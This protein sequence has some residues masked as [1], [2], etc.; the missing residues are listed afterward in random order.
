MNWKTFDYSKTRVRGVAKQLV[1]ND[2]S[3]KE[4]IEAINIVASFRSAHSYPMQSMLAHIRNKAYDVDMYAIVVRRLKRIPSI[5]AK[6]KRLPSMQITTMGD[7]GGIRVILRDIKAVQELSDSLKKSKTRNRLLKTDDYLAEP[8]H[9]GYRSI[10]LTY[11]YQGSKQDYKDFRVEVQIRSKVQHSWAT[12]VEVA[13]TFLRQ[14]MKAGQGDKQW[15]AFFQLI[16]PAFVCLETG[17]AIQASLQKRIDEEV[18]SLKVFDLL[19]SFT[20]A[21]RTIAARHAME[22]RE[23]FYLLTLDTR[24]KTIST[25]FFPSTLLLKAYEDYRRIEQEIAEDP[26]RDV[27]LVSADSLEDL[28]LAYPNYFADTGLFLDNLKKV[29]ASNEGNMTKKTP[30]QSGWTPV[31]FAAAYKGNM[32]MWSWFLPTR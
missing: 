28:K 29:L 31:H 25:Q 12:A 3:Q 8:K 9:S 11:S 6:L 10:H 30:V 21:A 32:T 2:L 1:A 13:G 4:K 16:S 5:L 27:V 20:I 24:K 22:K 19:S 15:L 18:G 7:I 26:T 14:N 17:A 23:G